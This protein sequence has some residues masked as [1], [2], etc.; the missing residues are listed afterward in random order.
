MPSVFLGDPQMKREHFFLLTYLGALLLKL[1]Y[2]N[3]L[4]QRTNII[5]TT[6]EYQEQP[7]T[8]IKKFPKRQLWGGSVISKGWYHT[9]TWM[10]CLELFG[11]CHNLELLFWNF[12][13]KIS[14]DKNLLYRKLSNYEWA[15]IT[16][17]QDEMINST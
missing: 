12:S 13:R 14:V 17:Q 16:N 6:N 3:K 15:G 7:L 5:I 8:I 11:Y 4:I 10:F 9:L 2:W 1:S